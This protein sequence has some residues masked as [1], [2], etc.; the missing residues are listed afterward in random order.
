MTIDEILAAPFGQAAALLH[1]LSALKRPLEMAESRAV[2][3]R[4]RGIRK[5]S[6]IIT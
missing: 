5:R 2:A 1:A 3:R 4:S 6:E